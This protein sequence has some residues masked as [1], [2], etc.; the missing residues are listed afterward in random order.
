MAAGDEALYQALSALL[1]RLLNEEQF[2]EST[3]KKYPLFF[4]NENCGQKSDNCKID[5]FE[6][7]LCGLKLLVW[8][9]A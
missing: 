7:P 4:T 3:I 5:P 1:H 8:P 2:M 6:N 9:Y